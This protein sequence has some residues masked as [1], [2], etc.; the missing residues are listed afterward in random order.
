MELSKLPELFFV[1]GAVTGLVL[2]MSFFRAWSSRKPFTKTRTT[3]FTILFGFTALFLVMAGY[4][5]ST[6][7]H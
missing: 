4:L 2:L 3:L 1:A 5:Q 7:G 6:Q